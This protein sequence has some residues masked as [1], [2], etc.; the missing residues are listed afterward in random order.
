M[1]PQKKKYLGWAL[2]LL[3]CFW[4]GN[5]MGA[6]YTAASGSLTAKLLAAL[7]IEKLLTP[8]LGLHLSPVFLLWGLGAA[9][10]A[11]V[12]ILWIEASRHNTMPGKEHGSAFLPVAQF[13]SHGPADRHSGCGDPSHGGLP[14]RQER[15]EIP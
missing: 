7:D 14:E 3:L 4:L 1:T 2:V 5:R 10:V 13:P 12:V 9:A 8:P 6:V 11:G 15:K